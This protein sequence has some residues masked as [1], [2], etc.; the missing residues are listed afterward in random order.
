MGVDDL[1]LGLLFLGFIIFGAIKKVLEA[2]GEQRARGGSG[3]TDYE[4]GAAEIKQFLQSL[5][6]G[7]TSRKPSESKTQPSR[8]T[9]PEPEVVQPESPSPEPTLAQRQ[10]RAAQRA[11]AATPGAQAASRSRRRTRKPA[12]KPA[13]GAQAEKKPEKA[14]EPLKKRLLPGGFGLKQA[15]VW[16]EIL[17][18]PV[19]FRRHKHHVPPSANR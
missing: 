6:A 14:P 12:G 19:S 16:A 3:S 5:G 17:G 1:I 10:R 7:E 4:A 8:P 2:T 15:V 11:Q 13:A 18:P 9:P